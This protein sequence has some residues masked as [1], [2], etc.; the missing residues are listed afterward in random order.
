[1]CG[2]STARLPYKH[3]VNS[4]RYFYCSTLLPRCM[5]VRPVFTSSRMPY[6]SSRRIRLSSFSSLSVASTQCATEHSDFAHQLLE[7]RLISAVSAWRRT[8]A[9]QSSLCGLWPYRIF[10]QVRGSCTACAIFTQVCAAFLR[11]FAILHWQSLQVAHCQNLNE[12]PM[13]PQL[14]PLLPRSLSARRSAR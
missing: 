8:R 5:A 3:A 1:M 9:P 11:Y 6:G 4:T 12:S 14:T 10:S 13:P 2:N 7:A